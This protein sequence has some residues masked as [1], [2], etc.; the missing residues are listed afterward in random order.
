MG[1]AECRLELKK[2]GLF[3]EGE[4]SDILVE[5]VIDRFNSDTRFRNQDGTID[6][7]KAKDSFQDLVDEVKIV[8]RQR[9]KTQLRNAA[10]TDSMFNHWKSGAKELLDQGKRLSPKRFFNS[11]F[12]G[13]NGIQTFTNGKISME[14]V[15][16][17]HMSNYMQQVESALEPILEKNPDY[18]YLLG[19]Q[20]NIFQDTYKG[21]SSLFDK[22]LTE[23]RRELNLNIYKALEGVPVK[24][25]IAKELADVIG[26][27][28]K[29]LADDI[30]KAG[31]NI[32]I[33]DFYAPHSHNAESILAAGP[34]E[35]KQDIA[36]RLDWEQTLPEYYH[37]HKALMEET[38]QSI[39]FH[40]T[41]EAQDFLTDVF[42]S[43]TQGKYNEM[44]YSAP[45]YRAKKRFSKGLEN[46]RRLEFLDG[47][48]YA[49][50][51]NRFSNVDTV[52]ALFDR[53][54][55][56][57]TARASMEMF[58]TTP[59]ANL[60][61]L[62]ARIV[63]DINERV[64]LTTKEKTKYVKELESNF[65]SGT[66][67][68]GRQFHSVMGRSDLAINAN[69]AKFSSFFRTLHRAKLGAM[70]ISAFFG[71]PLTQTAQAIR[72][73]G[74]PNNVFELFNTIANRLDFRDAEM[75]KLLGLEAEEMIGMMYN[76][77]DSPDSLA[78]NKRLFNRYTAGMMRWTG[79]GWL[80]SNARQASQRVHMRAM[81]R[82]IKKDFND[83]HQYV[84]HDLKQAGITEKEWNVVRRKVT[85]AEG[86]GREY[87]LP[88][89]IREV[90][91]KHFDELLPEEFQL[92]NAP[93]RKKDKKPFKKW[94]EKRE[95]H[96]LNARNDVE[97]KLKQYYI[98][99]DRYAVLQMD[100]RSKYLTTLGLQRGDFGG[101]IY[102]NLMQFKAQAVAS[103][104]LVFRE[105][106]A[107]SAAGGLND[108]V[109][110]MGFL[111]TS[112]LMGYSS[113][114]ARDFLAGKNP[115]PTDRV[116][117][118]IESMAA[119]GGLGFIYD[120]LFNDN[121]AYGNPL[122]FF[123]PTGGD[124]GEVLVTM[125]ELKDYAN[126]EIDDKQLKKRLGKR[127]LKIVKGWTPRLWFAR[128]MLD[129]Y[130]FNPWE[131]AIDPKAY[132]K[133]RRRLKKKGQT[134]RSNDYAHDW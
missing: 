25:P 42:H 69:A 66:G 82:H 134:Y 123:G 9:A 97:A 54:R 57:S 48:A 61:S 118:Y 128:G 7:A 131:K 108:I 10:A 38:G 73:K 86:S 78:Q 14:S 39:P 35:W 36:P 101:E 15:T 104:N 98:V 20:D 4:E 67:S 132:G 76:R 13:W 49:E 114:A 107:G 45:A 1:R 112:L 59:E 41:N 106:R 110:I 11:M 62:K 53:V 90:G 23:A 95:Q 120:V 17:R 63:A 50:Y 124:I 2:T 113:L 88:Q 58:G 99:G 40:T 119:S 126:D 100:E 92:K 102:R 130:A 77:F 70:N 80:T 32:K 87:L 26:P 115:R 91:K 81:A 37:E 94:N 65:E 133:R 89:N 30:N 28:Y 93:R 22:S 79:T 117:T 6:L 5:E 85:T 24:D 33:R 129:Y 12:M 127:S 103:S 19:I 122:S 64:D 111:G 74:T 71:D 55:D 29:T 116:S 121:R 3:G 72:V 34:L 105:G 56:T 44:G 96:I 84:K 47:N 51:A 27:I 21:I 31:G 60:E 75:N 109:P 16:G 43:I 46:T 83:L 18:K 52:G 8:N 68:L 125:S